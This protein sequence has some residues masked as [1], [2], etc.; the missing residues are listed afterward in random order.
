ML[1][2]KYYYNF[3]S[4]T[5]KMV[6]RSAINTLTVAVQRNMDIMFARQPYKEGYFFMDNHPRKLEDRY[7][8]QLTYLRVSVTDR[9]NL[10]CMYCM[11]RGVIEKVHHAHVLSYEELLRI[12]R[13][14]VDLGINK[15]RITGG[16]P[17]VRADMAEFL[18]RLGEIPCLSEVTL[19]TNGV[20]LGSFLE[21]LKAAG[22]RRINI[23]LD[24]LVRGK[25]E[26]ITGRDC[27]LQVLDSIDRAYAAGFDPLKINVV[28]MRGINDDEVEDLARLS[29]DRPFH[30][31][32]I[33]YMP[34]GGSSQDFPDLFMPAGDVAG[35]IEESLGSLEPVPSKNGDG[36]ARRFKIKGAAGEVGFISAV[37]NHFCAECN[38]LRLTAKGALRT[39]LLSDVETDLKAPLRQGASD[40]ELA[41]I[42][43]NGVLLKPRRHSLC[44][45]DGLEV[46]GRM[47]AIGG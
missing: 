39:C 14:A 15:I 4:F 24:S 35:L 44:A 16:E 21:T 2:T 23:S 18:P 47:S 11:P 45:P 9:C 6:Q 36:P 12:C 32:F 41:E 1:Y 19:T 7:G 27:L 46:N 33:E 30:V 5:I 17:L 13:I 31:R 38:R 3:G 43:R 28:V 37:S 26:L 20:L 42:F 40:S 10:R 22:I 34:M 25:Y 8:R 29:V